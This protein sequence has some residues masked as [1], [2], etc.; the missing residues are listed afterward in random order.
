MNTCL[1]IESFSLGVAFLLPALPSQQVIFSDGFCR[2]LLIL[3]YSSSFLNS[4]VDDFSSCFFFSS[5][6]V[7]GQVAQQGK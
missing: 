2:W 6:L 4:C 3:S 7:S 1:P 5:L